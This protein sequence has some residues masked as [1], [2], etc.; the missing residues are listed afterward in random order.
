MRSILFALAVLLAAFYCTSADACV[1][2]GRQ[3]RKQTGRYYVGKVIKE[4][5]PIRAMLKG[6]GCAVVYGMRAAF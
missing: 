6:A 3:F 1:L 2:Q 5:K 4:K